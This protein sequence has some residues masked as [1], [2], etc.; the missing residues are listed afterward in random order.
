MGAPLA[1]RVPDG[2]RTPELGASDSRRASDEN[3]D[4]RE[5]TWMPYVR[6]VLDGDTLEV[7]GNIGPSPSPPDNA[8]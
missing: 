2:L 3:G 6:S 5:N 4:W 7:S 8:A 1:G